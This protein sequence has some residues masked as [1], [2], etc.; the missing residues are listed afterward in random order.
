MKCVLQQISIRDLTLNYSDNGT[1]GVI[2]YNNNLNIRPAY[3]REFVYKDAQRN[4]VINTV[5]SNLPLNIMYWADCGNNKYEIIDGQQRTI[6]IC[7]FVNG[8]FSIND[9]YF[10]NLQQNEK[11]QILNYELMVYK[12]S[13]TDSEK[14]AWFKTINIA[15]EKLTEQELLNAVY[16]GPWLTAAKKYFSITGGPAASIGE[17]YISG[18]AIRQDFLE[19]AI[20]WINKD[21]VPAYMAKHQQDLKADDLWLHYKKVITWITN[22]FTSYY[23]E[24]KGLNW[25]ALYNTYNTNTYDAA[26]IAMEV[27]KLYADDSIENKKGIFEYVLGGSSDTKLL[28]IRLFSVKDKQIAYTNQTKAAQLA[29][30]SNCPHCASDTASSHKN[31]QWKLEDM[32]ADHVAAWSKGGATN[33]ANCQMLCRTHNR[34]KGNA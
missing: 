25:G 17:K 2:G 22:T 16:H 11:D 6:S 13:G 33:L 19:R 1:S 18:S 14:L 20:E 30:T 32:E 3:Q 28:E 26:K 31:K 29:K 15:G 4:A 21:N 12:C 10:H 7:Q 23:K 5:I 24:M 34:L 8:D 27:A 9:K